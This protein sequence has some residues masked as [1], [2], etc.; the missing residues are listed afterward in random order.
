VKK[1]NP[2]EAPDPTDWLGHSEDERIEAVRAYHRGARVHL[3]SERLH[4][5]IHAVVE[6]QL[7]TGEALVVETHG[8]LQR[9]G[10]NRHEAIHAVGK[11]LAEHIYDLLHDAAPGAGEDVNAV[12]F[13]ALKQ[14]TAAKWRDAG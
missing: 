14:L 10:L 11:V 7:A 9:E 2:D 13:Q 4:A 3:P 8:R 6:N 5:T 1:Y 12:Y